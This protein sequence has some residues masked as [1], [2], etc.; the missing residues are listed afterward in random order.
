MNRKKTFQHVIVSGRNEQ[1]RRKLQTDIQVWRLSLLASLWNPPL[2]FPWT[3]NLED[4]LIRRLT[5]KRLWIQSST[6]QRTMSL[7]NFL[8][9]MP[10]NKLI[11]KIPQCTSRHPTIYH[12]GMQCIDGH[13]AG[14]LWGLYVWSIRRIFLWINYTNSVNVVFR[15][16]HK[17]VDNDAFD[18]SINV[19]VIKQSRL[20]K[21]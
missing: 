2:K 10:T 21:W 9:R 6:R 13:G 17:L 8:E 12:F 11:P 14:V 5:A 7:V 15:L 19:S 3:H 20:L 16:S 1:C 4:L 18:P